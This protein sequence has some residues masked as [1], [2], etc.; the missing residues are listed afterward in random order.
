MTEPATTELNIRLE[1]GSDPIAGQIRLHN[2]TTLTFA[3]YVQ[4]IEAVE[5]AH[6]LGPDGAAPNAGN[7]GLDA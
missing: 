7:G 2:G 6:G 3:G 5:L 1:S 4:L